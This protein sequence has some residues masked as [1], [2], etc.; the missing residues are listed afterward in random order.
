M[1]KRLL[2]ALL[3]FLAMSVFA[4]VDVN[5]ATQAELDGVKGIGPAIATRITTERAK[6]PFKDWTDF[7]NR[8]SG[9]GEKTAAKLSEAGLTVNGTSFK[10]ISPAP[11]AA[12][13]RKATTTAGA[14]APV[15][16]ASKAETKAEAKARA[17]AEAKAQTKAKAET[18]A[19]SKA[20][21]QAAKKKA[22]A[23]AAASAAKK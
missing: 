21:T 9:V 11:A 17:K 2:A 8:V 22:K 16:A 23:E 19:A 1:F 6:A 5:K 14:E 10:G 7:V 4:A 13:A 18:Q 12:A 20:E 15:K 3:A